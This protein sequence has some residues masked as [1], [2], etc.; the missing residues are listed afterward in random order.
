MQKY[1]NC[2]E[3][4]VTSRNPPKA[5]AKNA[6][7]SCSIQRWFIVSGNGCLLEWP[8]V[9][10][11]SST[12]AQQTVDKLCNMF[13]CHGL[14]TTVVSD[15]GTSFQSAEFHKFMTANGILHCCVPP[16]HPASNGLAENMVKTVKQ[17]L[18][19]AKV[20]KEATMRPI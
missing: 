14:P 12:S 2:V 18:S 13:A 19:K 7:G 1:S 3:C 20:T 5:L 9:H 6:C 10:V 15:N 16:Y 11:A 8:E 4:S 17:A